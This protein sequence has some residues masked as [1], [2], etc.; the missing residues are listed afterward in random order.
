MFLPTENPKIPAVPGPMLPPRPSKSST[1]TF[2][3]ARVAARP[4]PCSLRARSGPTVDFFTAKMKP[5]S[6]SRARATEPYDPCP[7]RETR[8]TRDAVDRPRRRSRPNTRARTR[9]I[10]AFWRGMTWKKTRSNP[11]FV[12]LPT[13]HT[14][15]PARFRPR[16]PLRRAY[17]STRAPIL[18]HPR[19]G[20]RRNAVVG[21]VDG[22]DGVDG[23]KGCSPMSSPTQNLNPNPKP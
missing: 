22:V 12:G 9:G 23:T 13:P 7:A 20:G 16:G 19:R 11:K 10:W 6:T 5:L 21:T 14:S 1:Q 17:R 2:H 18:D 4:A 15:R 8:V 3:P